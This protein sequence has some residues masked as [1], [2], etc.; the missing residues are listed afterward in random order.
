MMMQQYSA[1]RASV[2]GSA[3]TRAFCDVLAA[4]GILIAAT[5]CS[6]VVHGPSQ[7]SSASRPGTPESPEPP[8]MG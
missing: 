4:V 1:R 3:A 7:I 2:I 6:P 5:G 8:E